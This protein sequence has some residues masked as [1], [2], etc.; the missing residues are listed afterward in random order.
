MILRDGKLQALL[1]GAWKVRRRYT[2]GSRYTPRY[3]LEK[4]EE[5]MGGRYISLAIPA[6]IAVL[7]R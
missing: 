3:I 1:G 7:L 4:E 2:L 6:S 5:V